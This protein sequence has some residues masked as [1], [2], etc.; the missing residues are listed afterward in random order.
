MKKVIITG[1]GGFIGGA[2]TKHLLEKGVTVYGVD[3][4]AE[5]FSAYSDHETFIPV[6]A[7]F[8]KYDRLADMIEDDIDVFYHFAWQGV[9]GAA[10]KDYALQLNNAKYACEAIEQAIKI[11]CKK[12]VFAGTMNE[13]EM[14]SYI[15]ADYFEPRY[16]Y[17]Y[18]AVKQVSEAIGKTLAFNNG[19]EFCTG[20]IAMAYGKNNYSMMI[21][22][23][24]M[25]N[26]ISNTPCKLIE[27]NDLYDMIYIDDI[28]RA[29]E[30][31]G[32]RGK[33][34]KSYYIGHRKITTFREI[35]ERIAEVLNPNCPLLFGEY[36]DV[37]S[38]VDY[39]NIDLDALYYDTGFECKANFEESIRKTAE[40]IKSE[41]I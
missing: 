40:W 4:S 20:R 39:D 33:N 25:K 5:K 37:P 1:A 18:S 28:V 31:I 14:D 41:G 35:I 38:G 6:V 24:V 19:I 3:I 2:L 32:E 8:S 36:P 26:L 22:N 34:M 17:I 11:G 16:T 10:F 30:A 9:F 23:V 12:F 27:G 15:K 13:Y 29:F 7:D 21:P